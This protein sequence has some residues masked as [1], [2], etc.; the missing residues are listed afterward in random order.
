MYDNIPV[1]IVSRTD[2]VPNLDLFLGF[3][4]AK[5]FPRSVPGYINSN[6]NYEFIISKIIYTLAKYY[7]FPATW[8]TNDANKNNW[9]L[10]VSTVPEEFADVCGKVKINTIEVIAKYQDQGS[11]MISLLNFIKAMA[12]YYKWEDAE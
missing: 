9:T 2:Q 11:K 1:S 5:K 8:K 6:Y 10:T 3:I 12:I 7:N 4:K